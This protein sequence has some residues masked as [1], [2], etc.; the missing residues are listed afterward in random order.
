M[1]ECPACE[2]HGFH[3]L[4]NR[5]LPCANYFL[6]LTSFDGTHRLPTLL[7]DLR[8]C[9]SAEPSLDPQEAETVHTPDIPN[10][11]VGQVKQLLLRQLG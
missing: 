6:E 11:K 7:I 1:I 5:P 3:D 8:S 9:L 2:S 10:L 4:G